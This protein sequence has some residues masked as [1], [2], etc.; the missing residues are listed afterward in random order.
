MSVNPVVGGIIVASL[1][2]AIRAE[3]ASLHV[4]VSESGSAAPVRAVVI[5]VGAFPRVISGVTDASGSG[6]LELPA[7][8]KV[9]IAVRTDTHGFRCVSAEQVQSGSVTVTVT[10]SVRVY[11]VVTD[12][13]GAP[14][15][16]V[17]V[18]TRYQEPAECRVRLDVGAPPART[19]E[20]GEYVVRNLDLER[21]PV[22][23]FQHPA[24]EQVSVDKSSFT[25]LDRLERR[26]ELN[27]RLDSR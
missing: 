12:S 11:G 16:D 23:E 22:L 8:D 5:A 18:T 19:N 20:R 13:R 4:Q 3:G 27:V 25:A 15:L 10:P 24:L 9:A 17:S 7:L 6:N 1:L 14:V 26:K 21:N 2:G